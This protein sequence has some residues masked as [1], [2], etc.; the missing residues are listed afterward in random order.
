MKSVKDLVQDID[1]QFVDKHNVYKSLLNIVISLIAKGEANDIFDQVLLSSMAV[2]RADGGTVY[3]VVDNKL[4]F[5]CAY[6]QSLNLRTRFSEDPSLKLDPIP[7]FKKDMTYNN[8]FTSVLSL[9]K[10]EVIHVKNIQDEKSYATSGSKVFDDYHQYATRSMLTIPFFSKHN[11]LG[12]LQLI[13]AKQ[14]ESKK[15]IPFEKSIQECLKSFVQVISPYLEMVQNINK[16]KSMANLL[17]NS[18]DTSNLE[19]WWKEIKDQES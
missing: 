16:N 6:N 19:L 18:A 7:L 15:I 8:G 3:I 2:S 9:E 11:P 12:V 10:K 14:L 5:L 1:S 13:N 4:Q 17:W